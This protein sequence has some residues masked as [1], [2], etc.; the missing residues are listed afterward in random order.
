MHFRRRF[1]GFLFLLPRHL[2]HVHQVGDGARV[3]II[4]HSREVLV[5]R[6]E[7]RIDGLLGPEN[8][9]TAHESADEVAERLAGNGGAQTGTRRRGT[10]RRRRRHAHR[11]LPESFSLELKSS[12]LKGLLV[13][14]R[15]GGS[16]AESRNFIVYFTR[17]EH[18]SWNRGHL[19]FFLP[20]R[21]RGRTEP[22]KV[23]VK[24]CL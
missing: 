7:A 4:L 1:D 2:L 18:S 6:V 3:G 23:L 20:L 14:G 11:T 12:I 5:D 10:A 17:L 13:S 21:A 22:R 16:L 24:E 15:R 8:V 19:V 9:E